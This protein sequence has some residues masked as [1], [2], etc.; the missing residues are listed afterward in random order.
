VVS[1]LSVA[2][3]KCPWCRCCPWPEPEVSVVSVLSVAE[4]ELSVVSVLSV[5]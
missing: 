2:E 4:P 1:V 5:A 3:P